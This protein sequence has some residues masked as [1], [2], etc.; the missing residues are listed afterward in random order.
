M[1]WYLRYNFKSKSSF[2]EL[3]K[4]FVVRRKSHDIISTHHCEIHR[5]GPFLHLC[6]ILSFPFLSS[7]P[8]AVFIL[9]FFTFRSRALISREIIFSF[10]SHTTF[11]KCQES[12]LW[13]RTERQKWIAFR[14][15]PFCLFFFNL[16]LRSDIFLLSLPIHFEHIKAE[17]ERGL[18]ETIVLRPGWICFFHSFFSHSYTHTHWTSF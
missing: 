9:H 5:F 13:N 14:F 6:S 15:S 1:C 12:Y 4:S 7:S 2:A 8:F 3:S 18:S 11:A 16:R 17:K 10:A